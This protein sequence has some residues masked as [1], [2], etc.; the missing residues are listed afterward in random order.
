MNNRENHRAPF[1]EL[2]NSIDSTLS[3]QQREE[4]LVP[5]YSFC[6][7]SIVVYDQRTNV[8]RARKYN[9]KSLQ[10]LQAEKFKGKISPATSRKLYKKIMTWLESISTHNE[11]KNN[12]SSSRKHLPTF[13]TLTL[14]STQKHTD[15]E[16]KRK[17]FDPF[18][19][20][21]QNETGSNLYFWRAEKQE[22]GNIHF[23]I[24]HDSYINKFK[25]QR[26]W[27]DIQ[28]RNGYDSFDK[29]KYQSGEA[30][31][32]HV[33]VIRD[34][35]T[36]P[37]YVLK[38]ALKQTEGKAVTGRVWGMS[39]KLRDI[40]PLKGVIDSEVE[41]EMKEAVSKEAV[42]LHVSDYVNIMIILNLPLAKT[43]MKKVFCY[44]QNHALDVYDHLYYD[45][46]N[47][48]LTTKPL[49]SQKKRSIIKPEKRA[50]Q[51][52]IT[53]DDWHGIHH[54]STADL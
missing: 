31:S 17:M 10:N 30:P 14:S 20:F 48:S 7:N 39:D 43:I 37:H 42:T 11:E 36:I 16:V 53:G 40:A 38:Y 34:L 3:Q 26:R 12:N 27:N 5:C 23:H 47:P 41:A 33:S 52:E 22:N 6:G 25:L 32:T 35:E 4:P 19:K 2:I 9:E 54:N 29:K 1:N 51:L 44:K 46:V 24:I 45:C 28:S 13:I 49:V 15:K 18:I 8:N 50:V 21:L